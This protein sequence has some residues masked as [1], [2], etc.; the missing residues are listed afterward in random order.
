M[1]VSK[2][3]CGATKADAEAIVFSKDP[4]FDQSYIQ[5]E[6]PGCNVVKDVLRDECNDVLQWYGNNGEIYNPL[7]AQER[8]NECLREKLGKIRE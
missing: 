5:L 7:P 6:Q 4:V 8:Q 3:V 2:L 1:G